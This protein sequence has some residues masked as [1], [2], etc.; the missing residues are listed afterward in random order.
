MWYLS[1]LVGPYLDDERA[2]G[3]SLEALKHHNTLF[4]HR[5]IGSAQQDVRN[6]V[7][8]MS[9]KITRAMFAEDAIRLDDIW[10]GHYSPLTYWK[11]D[12]FPGTC[13][14]TC[15]GSFKTDIYC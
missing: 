11:L 9:L 10:V 14:Y 12:G 2:E 15:W 5:M 4:L 1:H 13:V 7:A 3:L 8:E 6:S